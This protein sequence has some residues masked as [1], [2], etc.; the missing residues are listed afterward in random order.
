M[1]APPRSSRRRNHNG[2]HGRRFRARTVYIL[3]TAWLLTFLL[4]L[5]VSIK[6]SMTAKELYQT[7]VLQRKQAQELALLHPQVTALQQQLDALVRGRLPGLHPLEFDKIIPIDK[8]YVRNILFTQT[9]KP[10]DYRYE[11]KLTLKNSGLTAVHPIVRIIFFDRSGIQVASSTIGVDETGLP[12]LDVLER[13][14]VRSYN[15]AVPSLTGKEAKYFRVEV[16]LPDYQRPA[17]D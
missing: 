13:G 17:E 12:T 5:G 14:E 4:L 2:Y 3:I 7:T 8:D 10:G 15:Q 6:L 16:D 1:P 9:G 11:Y